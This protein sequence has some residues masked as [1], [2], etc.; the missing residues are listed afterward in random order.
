MT[1]PPLAIVVPAR[2]KLSTVHRCLDA[3]EAHAPAGSVVYLV[4]VGYSA[5]TIAAVH[6]RPPGRIGLRIVRAG[7]GPVLVNAAVN[8]ALA[9]I[10]EPTVCV[11]ENDVV[12]G[13]GFW[14]EMAAALDAFDADLVSPTIVDGHTGK[15]HFDPP[16][17]ELTLAEDGYRSRLVRRP[18]PAWPRVI[19][20]RRISHLEKHCFGGT[21]EAFRALAPFDE[22]VCTRTDVD[23]SLACHR[24]GLRL[25]MAPA[26]A[27]AF[28]GPPVEPADMAFFAYRWDL[29]RATRS[30]ERLVAKWQLRD[31]HDYLEF[32][33]EMRAFIGRRVSAR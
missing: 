18:K 3:L 33:H 14:V 16:V 13:Q 15:I 22:K 4:D 6:A 25:V 17:S 8:A 32:V 1:V 26:A 12:V 5:E 27:V 23:L 19:G 7:P 29:D 28:F 31:D 11:V 20:R 9:H 30:N 21:L 10:D 24:A 2:E